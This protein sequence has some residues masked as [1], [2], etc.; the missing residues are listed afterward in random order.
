[1]EATIRAP[2]LGRLYGGDLSGATYRGDV[3]GRVIWGNITGRLIGGDLMEAIYWR[4]F[5]VLI[6]RG[7]LIG[8]A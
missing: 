4:R 7:R 8:A 6:Y 3:S 2:Y 5:I 1:M